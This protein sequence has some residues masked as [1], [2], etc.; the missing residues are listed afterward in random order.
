M[1][2]SMIAILCVIFFLVLAVAG[3]SSKVKSS[4]DHKLSPSNPDQRESVPVTPETKVANGEYL[5]QIDSNSIEIKISGESEETPAQAFRLAEDVKQNFTD[6]GL[7]T[8]DE[9][10]F[11]YISLQK[12]EQPTIIKIGKFL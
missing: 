11:T 10:C 8:G 2:K 1:R 3:C 9:V 12:E 7:N 4:P 5:G 6:Y